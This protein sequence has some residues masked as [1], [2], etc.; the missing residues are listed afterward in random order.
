MPWRHMERGPEGR[1]ATWKV[2]D[3]FSVALQVEKN[4]ADEADS[5]SSSIQEAP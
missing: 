4:V 1:P 2:L 3:A 5:P